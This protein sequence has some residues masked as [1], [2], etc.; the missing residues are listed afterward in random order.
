MIDWVKE[1]PEK[2]DVQ[3]PKVT[4]PLMYMG[5]KVTAVENEGFGEFHRSGDW[6][7]W[8]TK[9]GELIS[10]TIADWRVFFHSAPDDFRILGVEL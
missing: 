4:M 6:I 3:K 2:E 10:M 5:R 1:I 8:E 9:D 7:D